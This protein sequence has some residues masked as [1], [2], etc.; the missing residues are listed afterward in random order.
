MHSSKPQLPT[1]TPLP[2]FLSHAPP[3][4]T[5]EPASDG[6]DGCACEWSPL[7]NGRFVLRPR[8][9]RSEVLP[10]DAGAA[11][12]GLFPQGSLSAFLPRLFSRLYWSPLH[13][14]NPDAPAVTAPV[15]Y[16]WLPRHPGLQPVVRVELAAPGGGQPSA[17]YLATAHEPLSP[18]RLAAV[19]LPR[20]PPAGGG[21]GLSAQ[22]SAALSPC[23]L[24]HAQSLQVLHQVLGALAFAHARG[25]P[26]GALSAHSVQVHAVSGRVYLTGFACPSRPSNSSSRPSN[27]PPRASR[28][29]LLQPTASP[30]SLWLQGRMSNFEYLMTLNHM[31][32][33]GTRHFDPSQHPLLPWV[34]DFTAPLSFRNLGLSKFRL[35][36]G[37]DQLSFTYKTSSPPHHVTDS[38]SDLTYYVYLA[39]CTPLSVLTAVVRTSF[40][41]GE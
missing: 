31:A 11:A 24:Q 32:G 14:S 2:S 37:D 8:P 12:A 26:H 3:A 22:D 25:V 27:S 38:L 9:A 4:G 7:G 41:P 36:K 21:T 29:P 6:P 10:P 40:V 28:G 39:R 16:D 1:E 15:P 30:V 33:R 20:P 17:A 19:R 34:V 23:S 13:R 35:N 18:P 5:P